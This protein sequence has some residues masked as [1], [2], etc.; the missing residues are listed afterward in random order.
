MNGKAGWTPTRKVA[1]GA[2]AI[3]VPLAV[4]VSWLISLYGLEVPGEVQAA[5]GALI[6]TA[7]AYL[8]PN[9]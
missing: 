3:G 9:G 7:S 5:M 4:V 2:G 8:L 6:A 1:G